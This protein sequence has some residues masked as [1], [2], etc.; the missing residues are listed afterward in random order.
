MIDVREPGRVRF[1]ITSDETAIADWIRWRTSEVTFEPAGSGKTRV[2][3]TLRFDRRLDP[4]WYFG[5]CER[6]G[7]SQ[8]ASYLISALATPP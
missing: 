2:R 7:A 4:A 1:R 6:L 5:P 3:W 8:A